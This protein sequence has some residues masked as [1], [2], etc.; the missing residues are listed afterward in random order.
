MRPP[1]HPIALSAAV[2]AVALVGC[3]SKPH[4]SRPAQTATAG[5][6]PAGQPGYDEGY[7][8]DQG[9]VKTAPARKVS[10]EPFESFRKKSVAAASKPDE[11]A[12]ETDA[13]ADITPAKT[14]AAARPAAPG[15]RPSAPPAMPPGAGGGFW[16][17]VGMKTLSGAM[18][19]P[20]PAGATPPPA[21]DEETA[22]DDDSADDEESETESDDGE[23]SDDDS[24]D[25][26]DESDESDDESEDETEDDDGD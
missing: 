26:S 1:R 21:G 12:S 14:K 5:L 24:S 19:G 4:P 20:P 10:Y 6:M 3:E 13:D 11:A 15:P 9:Q 25:E 16:Q 18:G 8:I 23:T 2:F 17:R 7:V 22:T